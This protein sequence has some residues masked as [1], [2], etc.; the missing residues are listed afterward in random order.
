MTDERFW[1][2]I[3]R[4]RGGSEPTTPSATPEAMGDLLRLEDDKEVIGFGQTFV[5]KLCEINTWPLW[6]AGYVL[7]GGMGDDGFHYFRS[8]VIGKGEEAFNAAKTDPD[9]ISAFVED[10]CE[11]DNELLEYVAVEVAEERGLD[12]PRD[13][14]EDADPDA[15]PTGSSWEE[16]SVHLSFPKSLEVARRIGNWA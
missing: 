6:G 10:E 7:G 5:R 14:A 12:D 9:A 11:L 4:A 13:G 1:D 3:S 16:E 15:E 2:L 8:W